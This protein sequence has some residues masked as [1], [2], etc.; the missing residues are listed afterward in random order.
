MI[1]MHAADA[2]KLPRIVA[3]SLLDRLR[4]MPAVVVTGSRQTGKSTLA[5]ELATGKQHY[6]RKRRESLQARLKVS[7][8]R[9][10]HG[11]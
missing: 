6:D 5:Q 7:C 1:I 8:H 4:V 3:Q 11:S 2:P 9:D 10:S